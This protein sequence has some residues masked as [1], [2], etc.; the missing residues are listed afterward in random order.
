M[1]HGIPHA[2]SDATWTNG[3]S[4]SVSD[5]TAGVSLQ[6]NRNYI[7]NLA[8]TGVFG[9][10]WTSSIDYSLTFEFQDV[11]CWARLDSLTTCNNGGKPLTAIYAYNP[12]GYPLSFT[13]TDGNGIWTSD[14]GDTLTLAANTWTLAHGS[15]AK[16]TFD[17]NG[18]PLTIKDERAIGLTYAYSPSDTAR[19]S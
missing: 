2:G 18:R 16:T 9:K 15:G 8:R 10:K 14:H 6:V 11:G 4:V 17:T 7:K 5:S 13:D 3:T 19:V 12:S 1:S